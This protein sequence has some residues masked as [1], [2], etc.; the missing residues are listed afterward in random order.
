MILASLLHTYTKLRH[1]CFAFKAYRACAVQS[2]HSQDS[3]NPFQ[4]VSKS[5]ASHKAELCACP[6]QLELW[7]LGQKVDMDAPARINLFRSDEE[8]PGKAGRGK[9]SVIASVRVGALDSMDS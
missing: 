3:K 9:V 1:S 8:L 2:L 5:V 4:C 7:E 6:A